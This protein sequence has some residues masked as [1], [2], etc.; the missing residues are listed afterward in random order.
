LT[1]GLHTWKT[2]ALPLD[3]KLQPIFPLVIFEIG[4]HFLCRLAWTTILLF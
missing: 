4:S 3:L 2:G 1:S